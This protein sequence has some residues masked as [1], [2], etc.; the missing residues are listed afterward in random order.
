VNTDQRAKSKNTTFIL[1][2]SSSKATSSFSCQQAKNPTKTSQM[3]TQY[4]QDTILHPGKI[5]K[6]L[7]NTLLHLYI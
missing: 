1:V 7:Y 4:I 6:T 3:Y 5:T 2:H